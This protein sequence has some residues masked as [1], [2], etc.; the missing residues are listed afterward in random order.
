M[1]AE[2]QTEL[3]LEVSEDQTPF[4]L[5]V[6]FPGYA[7]AL[8]FVRWTSYRC[9]DCGHVSRRDYWTNSVHIGPRVRKCDHCGTLF[10][11]RACEWPEFV[12]L[13]KLR[14]FFPP[15]LV[16]ICGGLV[17]AGVIVSMIP[18]HDWR[19]SAISVTIALGPVVFWGIVRL[20]WVLVSISRYRTHS[21]VSSV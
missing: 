6:L 3:P 8:G 13:K 11:D 9:P 20:P 15:L 19:L 18:P 12:T 7:R 16:G 1:Q 2:R 5:A 14:V 21:R 10:D 17:L 4:P